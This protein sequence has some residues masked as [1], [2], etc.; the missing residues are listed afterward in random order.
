[1]EQLSPASLGFLALLSS[2]SSEYTRSCHLA[3]GLTKALVRRANFTYLHDGNT[4]QPEEVSQCL[5]E[6]PN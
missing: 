4:R 1:M 2:Q 6:M 3:C 5:S